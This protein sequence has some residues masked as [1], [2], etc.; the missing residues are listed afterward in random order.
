MQYAIA[1]SVPWSGFELDLIYFLCVYV[2][3]AF[4]VI[5]NPYRGGHNYD[6]PP[7]YHNVLSNEISIYNLKRS[8]SVVG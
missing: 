6:P 5:L 2:P 4:I 1:M 7:S 8:F 3:I